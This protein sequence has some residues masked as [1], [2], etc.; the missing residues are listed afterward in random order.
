MAFNV[1]ALTAWVNDNSQELITK[2]VL[3]AETVQHITVIPGIKYKERLKYLDTNAPFIA[4][5]CGWGTSGTTTLTEK[6][7][8]VTSL[9]TTEAL[10]PD[11]LEHYSLQLSMKA[12]KNTAI[13][14]EQLY[15][16]Q[17]VKY[18]QKNIELMMWANTAADSTNFEGFTHL[19]NADSDVV[20]K[21]FNWTGT[22]FTASDYTTAI[23]AAY[24]GLPSEVQSADDL[25]LFI[26][27]DAYARL[28][29]AYFIA[30]LYHVDVNN[31]NPHGQTFVFPGISNLTIVPVNGLNGTR[32]GVLT[33]SSNL[34][35]CTDLVSEE[36][37]LQTWYSQD[38]Q[39][40]R[41]VAN[42]KAG[43]QYYFGIYIVFMQ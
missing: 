7:L 28:V 24:N 21:S 13:P 37:K 33:P 41:T 10:C 5:G 20:D 35:Y 22:T 3:E 17:K 8:L 39:E 9:R 42:F 40:V 34:I 31:Q 30:N 36:D 27:H 12:G 2:A 15:A 6:D 25:T 16:E 43:V 14:F 23:F 19:M 1:G 26:G 32:Y 38:N 4:G 29:N 11:D 18:I